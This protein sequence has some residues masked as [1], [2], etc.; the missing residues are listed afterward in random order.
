L[1]L[2][3]STPEAFLA[4]VA[5]AAGKA[6]LKTTSTLQS[7]SLGEFEYLFSRTSGTPDET[8]IGL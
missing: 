8:G 5:I 3:F 6:N 7:V 4:G 1:G 2:I